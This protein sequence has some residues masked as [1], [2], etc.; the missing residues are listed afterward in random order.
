MF[1]LSVMSLQS[2]RLLQQIIWEELIS[3]CKHFC[4]AKST[5]Q[6]G[7][8]E[9]TE[10][11]LNPRPL[12]ISSNNILSISILMQ[13]MKRFLKLFCKTRSRNQNSFSRITKK[14]NLKEWIPGPLFLCVTRTFHP[15]QHLCKIWK[16]SLNY[17]ARQEAEIITFFSKKNKGK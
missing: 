7:Q 13:N 10:K 12:F 2:I 3:P 1:I 5:F 11:E 8:R 15:F 14:I 17:L 9:I 16:D 4:H 6:E